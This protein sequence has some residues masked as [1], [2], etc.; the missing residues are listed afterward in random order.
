MY[1]KANARVRLLASAN[2]YR[3]ADYPVTRVVSLN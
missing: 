1:W 3:Y 2:K